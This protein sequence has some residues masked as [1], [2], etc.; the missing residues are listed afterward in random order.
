M[1]AERISTTDIR[2]IGKYGVLEVTLPDNKACA[3]AKNLVTR[4]KNLYP[5]EDG[6][7]YTCSVNYKTHTIII[8]VVKPEDVNRKKREE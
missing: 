6:M 7:T 2:S 3:S 5:R 1:V 4:V 8:K